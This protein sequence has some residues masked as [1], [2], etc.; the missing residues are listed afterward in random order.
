MIEDNLDVRT[1][2][3]EFLQ[4]H[5]DIKIVF[6]FDSAEAYL[7]HVR[8]NTIDLDI[9]LLDIGLPGMNGVDAINPILALDPDLNIIML[10]ANMDEDQ[11][12]QAIYNGA[13]AYIAKSKSLERIVDAIRIVKNGGS[14]MSPT[15]AREIFQNLSK[16][17]QRL[18]FEQLT[19]RQKEVLEFLSE[20]FSY[21][22]IAANLFLSIETV[23]SHIKKLYKVLHVSNKKE[24][25]AKYLNEKK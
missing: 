17:N 8:Q 22:E 18:K 23:R 6:S 4:L 3:I 9:L 19:S 11:V 10:T 24:A 25:I 14:Y 16:K 15:I 13:V 2:V 7:E 21:S 5:D 12:L 20:G 1:F